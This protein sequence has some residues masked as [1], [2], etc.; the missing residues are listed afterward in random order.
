MS[1]SS[2]KPTTLIRLSLLPQLWRSDHSERNQAHAMSASASPRLTSCV[3]RRLME[4][5]SFFSFENNA[6]WSL[7]A[8]AFSAITI[9][10]ADTFP[11][12]GQ[13]C[14]WHLVNCSSYPSNTTQHSQYFV[15]KKEQY[16]PN[17]SACV[18]F[19]YPLMK[20]STEPPSITSILYGLHS[21]T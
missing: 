5:V 10:A 6:G 3:V 20:W 11:V 12:W 8:C 15:L 18:A 13:L 19:F 14:S 2:D 4:L 7:W 1:F 21:L 16:C 17:T 9:I